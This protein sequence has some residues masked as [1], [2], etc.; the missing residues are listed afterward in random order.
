MFKALQL[1]FEPATTWEK[2][3]RAERSLW[4]VLF[5]YLVPTI[6]IACSIEAWGLHK[7]GNKPS[8]TNFIERQATP[9]ALD[10]IIRYEIVQALLMVAVV[11]LLAFTLRALMKSLNGTATYTLVYTAIA[12][13][14]SP[15]FLMTAVDAVPFM[16]SWICRSIGAIL[17]AKVFYVG[18]VRVIRPDPTTALGIY[19]TGSFLL[20]AFVGLTHFIALQVLEH[21]LL[22]EIGG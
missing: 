7:F 20:A 11:F 18:L 6:L 9:V 1:I 3:A 8:V 10:I 5:L 13:S 19:M 14:F 22:Q 12:Y 4:Q 21:G 15:I 16:N 17:A 2:I